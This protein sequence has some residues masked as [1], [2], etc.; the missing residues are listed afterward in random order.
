MNLFKK[1]NW[2]QP[3]YKNDLL[4]VLLNGFLAAILGGILAGLLDFLFDEILNFPLS[5]SLI[6][7]CYL[8]GS[9][10]RKGYYSF[11]ILYPVLSIGFMALALVFAKFA[12]IFCI[13]PSMSTFQFLIRGSFYLNVLLSPIYY[14]T[15]CIKSFQILYLIIG[16]LN[17]VIYIFAF[18]FCYQMVKGRN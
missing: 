14:I 6:I 8:L 3:I 16:I 13:F 10:M 5:F 9:R 4:N 1:Y 18:R 15:E 12:Y 17:L 2:K 11:H 7:I